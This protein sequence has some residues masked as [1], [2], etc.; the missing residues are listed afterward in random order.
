MVTQFLNIKKQ[1]SWWYY[2]KFVKKASDKRACGLVYI[3]KPLSTKLVLSMSVGFSF[4]FIS[5]HIL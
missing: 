3:E 1:V 4:D 2:K 5:Y